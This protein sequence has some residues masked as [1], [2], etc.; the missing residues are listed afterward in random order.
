MSIQQV[1]P[2]NILNDILV[3]CFVLND[4]TISYWK[5]LTKHFHIHY[6]ILIIIRELFSFSHPVKLLEISS[7][8][9]TLLS[10]GILWEQD[11]ILLVRVLEDRLRGNRLVN[12][13]IKHWIPSTTI[14]VSESLWEHR[15]VIQPVSRDQGRHFRGDALRSSLNNKKNN[16]VRTY[17]RLE[18]VTEEHFIWALE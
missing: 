15:R 17:W 14:W 6:F 13:Q 9:R 1:N 18:E 7:M 16:L 3:S 4:L 11:M 5:S 10:L 12:T 8:S 2:S